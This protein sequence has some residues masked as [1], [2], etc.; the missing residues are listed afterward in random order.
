[1][2]RACAGCGTKIARGSRCSTCKREP[3]DGEHRGT[4]RQ[5]AP[6]VA[7]GVAICPRCLEP[8]RPG[9]RWHLGHQDDRSAATRPE[10]ATCNERA[11]A[12][13]TNGG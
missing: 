7:R 9:E 1:M 12:A 10:H 11:A 6:I 13:R 3:Y 8:I 5:W 2:S 4:R